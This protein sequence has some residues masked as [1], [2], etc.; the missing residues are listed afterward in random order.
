MSKKLVYSFS[1]VLVL[2]SVSNAA[3]IFWSDG[4]AN[5]NHLWTDP[6]N[7]L[8]GVVPGPGDEAQILSPEADAGHGPI[9]RDGMDIR[10]LGLKNELPGRPGKPELTMTGGNLEITDFVWWGDYD[11]IEAYWYH[12][13]GTVTVANE[14]ELGWGPG[15]GGAGT[16]D[17]TGG[18]I[19]A[20]NLVIPTSSG[21][22]GNFYLRGG[23][24]NVRNPG[25]LKINTN[26]LIDFGEGVL[27]LEGDETA[28]I[29]DFI[30]AGQITAYG[31]VGTVLATYGG[32]TTRVTAIGALKAT[33][34]NP[35]DEATD[36]LREVVLGW[37]PGI[38][39]PPTNGHKVYFSENFNNVKDGIGGITQDSNSYTPPQRLDLGTTYYWRVDE[40]NGPPDHTV[41]Q[42]DVWQFTTEPFAYAIENI[43]ATASSQAANR[44][45]ENT[46]NGSGLDE[47]GLL[48]GKE[49]DDNMWVS[50]ITG[51]QP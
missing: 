8:G 22:Y 9:I 15:T 6:D 24:F 29:N 31:G 43:T 42:G 2:G 12:R 27:V 33:N 40:V 39:V 38:Y 36:V 30:A 7:W 26:G 1:F 17:M 10:L 44:G 37:T 34:P 46:V 23:T 5:H 4:D 14:F 48:H 47:S 32:L 20:G 25:G 18:T 41:Y 45:P 35:A 13:G 3:E 51:P 50:D 21:A 16:L 19:S 49:G 11:G 28:K